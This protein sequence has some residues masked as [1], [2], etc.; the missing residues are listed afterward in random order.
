MT[1]PATA[2]K[3]GI[4]V[5]ESRDFPA[6]RHVVTVTRTTETAYRV[7][8]LNG[9]KAVPCYTATF[10][11]TTGNLP[12]G[13]TGRRAAWEYMQQRI[14]ELTASAETVGEVLARTATDYAAADLSRLSGAQIAALRTADPEGTVHH[15]PG[16]TVT[17]L[18][19]LGRQHLGLLVYRTVGMRRMVAGVQLNR[20]GRNL[21]AHVQTTNRI[22]A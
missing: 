5:G 7:V 13:C 19:S 4:Q 17:T 2:T 1:I 3:T 10:D 8:V 15:G 9:S 20:H 6:G 14:T 11:E 16:V 12:I 21:A 18:R 22:A